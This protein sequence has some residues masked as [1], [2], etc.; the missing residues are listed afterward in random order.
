M[1]DH[2]VGRAV[3]YLRRLHY[4]ARWMTPSEVLGTLIAE[5]RMLEVAVR[6]P[7]TRDQWR[8]LR[9]VVDQARAWSRSSTVAC[10][11]T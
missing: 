11:P 6:R 1:S 3:D 9:F 10:A 2:P 8:R 7:R 4:T 5:R